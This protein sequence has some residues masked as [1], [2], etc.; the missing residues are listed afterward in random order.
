MIRV[1][2]NS[3]AARAKLRKGDIV[4]YINDVDI[5]GP[6]YTTVNLT[7]MRGS[8]ILH[9]EIERIPDKLIDVRHEDKPEIP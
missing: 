7:V 1:Y 9:F 4:K 2:R 6:S 3:P 5:C 8:E